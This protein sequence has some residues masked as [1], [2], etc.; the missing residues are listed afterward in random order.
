VGGTCGTH[1]RGEECV[2]GFFG[3]K[4]GRGVTLI[5]HHHLVLRSRMSRRYT[6]SPHKLHY[7]VCLALLPLY[8]TFSENEWRA[9]FIQMTSPSVQSYRSHIQN[10]EIASRR[11]VQYK[12]LHNMPYCPRDTAYYSDFLWFSSVP[13]GKC[14]DSRPLS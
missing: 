13:A 9:V 11:V 8:L 4:R 3:A 10:T 1:G 7:A 6:S 14:R 5:S 2:H 12:G